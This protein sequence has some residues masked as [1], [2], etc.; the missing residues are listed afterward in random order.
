MSD[1]LTR[2]VR[3][4]VEGLEEREVPSATVWLRDGVLHVRGT[5]GPDKVTVAYRGG[6]IV[7]RQPGSRAKA[8]GFAI[9]GVNRI[10]F[11]GLAGNDTFVNSTNVPAIVSTGS[12]N[13]FVST[14]TGQ[15]TITTGAGFNQLFAALGDQVPATNGSTVVLLQQSVFFPIGNT[16]IISLPGQNTLIPFGG[17]GASFTNGVPG[18][19]TP[20]GN[21]FTNGLGTLPTTAGIGTFLPGNQFGIT[22]VASTGAP[23]V[24]PSGS[25]F[26][27]V[28]SGL[29]G[30][31]VANGGTLL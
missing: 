15:D 10:V 27:T 14:L 21:S 30:A 17:S 26:P 5:S 1:P 8:A 3:P 29:L 11:Q 6:R 7:V 16:A 20:L 28:T 25:G 23:L 22:N 19:T 12:G 4:R 9:P 31:P 13:N 18:T 24:S 2:K